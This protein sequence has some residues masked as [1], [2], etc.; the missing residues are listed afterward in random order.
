MK[1]KAASL[2]LSRTSNPRDVSRTARVMLMMRS[3]GPSEFARRVGLLRHGAYFRGAERTI[4][5]SGEP[6]RGH[7]LHRVH[8]GGERQ[9]VRWNIA[10]RRV[11]LIVRYREKRVV[12]LD[13]SRGG[14][15]DRGPCSDLLRVGLPCPTLP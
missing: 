12:E 14:P 11:L 13:G 4:G 5:D 10:R 8:R 3:V 2:P 7:A 1:F 6:G 9:G 15:F